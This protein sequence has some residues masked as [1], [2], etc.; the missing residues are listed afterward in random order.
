MLNSPVQAVVSSVSRR[1]V[2][3]LI[4]D[5]HPIVREGLSALLSSQ[6]DLHVCGEA[7]SIDEGMRQVG[8]TSP[9]VVIVDVSLRDQNGLELVRRINVTN[10]SLPVLVLSM[11]EDDLYARRAL[12]AGALG[13]LNKQRASRNIVAAVRCV[14]A[15]QTYVDMELQSERPTPPLHAQQS[16]IQP[17]VTS[18]TDREL[19]IFQMIGTGLA[20][21][22]IADR[23]LVNVSIV[24]LLRLKIKSK[25]G[26]K[27]STEMS[28]AATGFV[29]ATQC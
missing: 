8:E 27:N 25:L 18:L 20:T 21:S 24:E 3:V 17:D 10:P 23:L 22:E 7:D 2:R 13:Y 16:D 28:C 26:L 6:P 19:E 15:G 29:A 1:P 4:V 5:D 14:S 11:Y 12:D 9:S